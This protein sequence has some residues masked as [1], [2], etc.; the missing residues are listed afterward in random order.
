MGAA[1][2]GIE[3]IGKPLLGH[4]CPVG[5]QNHVGGSDQKRDS[6]LPFAQP[7]TRLLREQILVLRPQIRSLGL[8]PQHVKEKEGGSVGGRY[9][10]HGNEEQA[11]SHG[12]LCLAPPSG[13]CDRDAKERMQQE[14]QLKRDIGGIRGHEVLKLPEGDHEGVGNKKQFHEIASSGG[15]V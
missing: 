1:P 4:A 9:G 5:Q 8:R 2:Q 7:L 6:K 15:A 11:R 3:Q 10:P 13:R 12:R 14:H